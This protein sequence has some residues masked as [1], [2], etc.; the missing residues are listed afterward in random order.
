MRPG[1]ITRLVSGRLGLCLAAGL[2][3]AGCGETAVSPAG[4]VG[5]AERGRRLAREVGCGACHRIPGVAWPQGEVGPTLEGFGSRSLIAGRFPNQ[6]DT[7]AAFV[8]NAPAFD[9]A[10]GM[11]AMP[12]TETQSRDVAAF[13]LTL[14]AR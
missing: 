10:T 8:R 6:P 13:L 2:V 3:L 12:L 9:P 11:P 7:L 14:D 4:G 1:S 5:D